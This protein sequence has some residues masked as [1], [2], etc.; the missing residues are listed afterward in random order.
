[1]MGKKTGKNISDEIND[2]LQVFGLQG[3]QI[4]AVTDAGSNVV[5]ACKLLK[6]KHH[7]CLGHSVHNLITA[8]GLKCT[9][10]L[11]KIVKKQRK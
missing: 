3:K 1:M 9:E 6:M 11:E 4:T 7:K 10:Q 5:L 8:D 2:V